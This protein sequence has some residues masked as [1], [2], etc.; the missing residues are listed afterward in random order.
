MQTVTLG[1]VDFSRPFHTPHSEKRCH[2]YVKIW[3]HLCLFVENIH[4]WY[5]WW[6][7]QWILSKSKG[8]DLFYRCQKITFNSA[9][10]C[11]HF[12]KSAESCCGCYSHVIWQKKNFTQQY[13]IEFFTF[14]VWLLSRC[15]TLYSD[16]SFFINVRALP[17]LIE[18][19]VWSD[20]NVDISARDEIMK[21][22]KWMKISTIGVVRWWNCGET[23]TWDFLLIPMTKTRVFGTSEWRKDSHPDCSLLPFLPFSI[24]IP[25]RAILN[26]SLIS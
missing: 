5:Q 23:Q 19:F 10:C 3:T 17:P 11:Q 2:S 13:T 26:P 22:K 1:A 9:A 21:G 25:L 18:V 20:G 24:S 4:G 15:L 8:C 12:S 16:F 7:K 6:R 14:P